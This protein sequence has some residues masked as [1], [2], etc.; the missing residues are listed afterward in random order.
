MLTIDS[1][2]GDKVS[3]IKDEMSVLE[4]VALAYNFRWHSLDR[5]P[6]PVA[7]VGQSRWQLPYHEL[8][9]HHSHQRFIGASA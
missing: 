3:T 1:E 6:R 2:K 7:I 4:P 8:S 5:W 9:R